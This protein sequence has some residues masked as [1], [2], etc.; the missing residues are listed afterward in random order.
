MGIETHSKTGQPELG[1][2][3]PA[4]RGLVEQELEAILSSPGFRSSR[5]CHDFLRFVVQQTLAGS[6]ASIKER[7]IAITVFGRPDDYEPAVDSIVRVK[8][9]EVR[10]KLVEYYGAHPAGRFRIDLQPGNYVPSF[11]PVPV[12]SSK[13]PKRWM[14]AAIAAGA[15]AIAV[16]SLAWLWAATTAKNRLEQIWDPMISHKGAVLLAMPSPT[17]QELYQGK[18]VTMEQYYVGEGAAYGAAIFAG[19]LGGHRQPYQVK[20]G[21]EVSFVDLRRQPTVL[22]GAYSSPLTLDL[23]Q[24]LRY[25][26]RVV[27]DD[28]SRSAILDSQ[29]PSRSW[30]E[31]S[32]GRPSVEIQESFSMVVRLID[33]GIGQPLI[34]AAGIT[35]RGTHTAVEFLSSESALADFTRRAGDSWVRKNLQVVLYSKIHAHVPGPPEVLAWHIW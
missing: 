27:G 4:N 30:A 13:R 2:Q 3:D 12:A 10:K 1:W 28:W 31:P 29:D 7:S 25:R 32:F 16:P 33:S 11:V 26:F 24:G 5:R 17:I 34:I 22:L 21:R 18:P 6:S 23:T 19:I 9:A 35:A 20:I 8:A 14:V 15:L